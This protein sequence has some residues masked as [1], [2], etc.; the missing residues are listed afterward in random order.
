MDLLLEVPLKTAFKWW[1]VTGPVA[2]ATGVAWIVDTFTLVHSVRLTY[3]LM[4]L[5][6]VAS[7]VWHRGRF[8][9]VPP[10]DP[11]QPSRTLT[12]SQSTRADVELDA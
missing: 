1:R 2:A 7:I 6:L 12:N 11:P 8:S 4:L 3:S 9:A 10:T 5:A